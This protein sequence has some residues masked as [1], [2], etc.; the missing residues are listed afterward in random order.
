MGKSITADTGH[1]ELPVPTSPAPGEPNHATG[2][3]A[4]RQESEIP[5]V[6]EELPSRHGDSG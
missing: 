4:D 5:A 6:I 3:V 1:A 2:S